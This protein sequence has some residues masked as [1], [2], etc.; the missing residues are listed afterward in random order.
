MW[1]ELVGIHELGRRNR[2]GMDERAG[3][4]TK[5]HG[6][7][8]QG[9]VREPVGIQE[10]DGEI[11]QGWMRELVGIQELGQRNKTGIEER[12]GMDTGVRTEK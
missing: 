12:A 11:E 4:D 3:R 9:W 6:E 5:V 2:T 8:E 7:I 10:L 1:R